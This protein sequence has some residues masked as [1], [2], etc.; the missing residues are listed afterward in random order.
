MQLHK[1][2]RVGADLED[3]CRVPCGSAVAAPVWTESL[4]AHVSFLVSGCVQRVGLHSCD[5]PGL[6]CPGRR[7]LVFVPSEDFA[8]T[9]DG[10]GN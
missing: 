2:L 8:E 7:L 4:E 1:R 6:F 3:I 5:Q 9:Q 10:T